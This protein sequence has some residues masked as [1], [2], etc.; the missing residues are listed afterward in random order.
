MISLVLSNIYLHKLDEF[1]ETVLIPQH[2]R[3]PGRKANP[4]Y[5]AVKRELAQARRRGDRAAARDLRRRM[6]NLPSKDLRD[7]GY[8]RLR[9]VRYADD[10]ILGFTGPK[11]EAEQ[12]KEQLATFLR[13]ELKLELSAHKTLL[14][15][16]RTRAARFLGYEII[17]QQANSKITHGR[18][19]ANGQIALRAP[20]DVITA[21]CAPYLKHGKPWHRGPL[22][23]LDDYDI[24]KTFGAEYRGV[25]G[26]YL[27]ATDVWRFKRLHWTA[28]TSM[29]KRWQPSTSPR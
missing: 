8:R 24:V 18:R 12:T 7:P 5:S 2:T 23:N 27:L 4:A 13:D 15:H 19:A 22:Q 9:Y 20:L 25:I 14:T 26:Y 10:Q 11:A 16:A 6:R 3:G 1:V 29:L 28:A 21:K 17:V